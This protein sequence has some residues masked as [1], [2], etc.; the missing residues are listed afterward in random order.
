MLKLCI[1][2]YADD[3]VLMSESTTDLQKSLDVFSKYCELWKLNVN[4]AK[5]KNLVFTKGRMTQGRFLYN[6]QP[7]ENVNLKSF[8]Y[9]RYS[10]VKI[11]K[12]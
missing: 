1:L 2:F 11:W 5:T 12:L 10:H 7:I 6:D 8:C 3:T 9:F 4:I